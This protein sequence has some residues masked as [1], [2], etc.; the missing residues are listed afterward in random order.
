MM[1]GDQILASYHFASRSL[2]NDKY[3]PRDPV[4]R[5]NMMPKN[6]LQAAQGD[7]CSR[8]VAGAFHRA[9]EQFHAA[10]IPLLLLLFSLFKSQSI[11]P[12]H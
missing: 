10:A 1:E 7:F 2:H 8:K 3:V 6:L 5:P 12:V 9:R 11:E 4:V